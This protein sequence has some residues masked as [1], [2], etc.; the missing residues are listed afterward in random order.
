MRTRSTNFVADRSSAQPKRATSRCRVLAWPAVFGLLSSFLISAPALAQQY[1]LL[2]PGYFN[3]G[4]RWQFNLT[5]DGT[6]SSVTWEIVRAELVGSTDTVV[7][8]ETSSNFSNDINVFLDDTA[9]VI[10]HIEET[11]LS[12]PQRVVSA[13]FSDPL[14]K[15]P[16]RIDA[17]TSNAV[18]GRGVWFSQ[19]ASDPNDNWTRTQDQLVSFV[20]R[21][22]LTVPAFPTTITTTRIVVNETWTKSTGEYGTACRWFWL[23]PTYGFVAAD[24]HLQS[25]DSAGS[26]GP[27]VVVSQRLDSFWSAVPDIRIDGGSTDPTSATAGDA[28]G[29][30]WRE[31]CLFL[32]KDTTH[33]TDVILSADTV[34]DSADRLLLNDVVIPPLAVTGTYDAAGSATVP[35]DLDS[36]DYFIIARVDANDYVAELNELNDFVLNNRLAV[37]ARNQA[38]RWT[39]YP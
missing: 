26:T 39:L 33:V 14:E 35:A 31:I 17:S 4:N 16:R 8:R 22:D 27:L 32:D 13:T 24:Y 37:T 6:A 19:V 2:D 18:L 12:S 15:I 30:S 3:V 11:R 7:L 28:I 1:E 25:A 34:V 21:E 5:I 20:A 10:A 38:H 9:M 36:G 29:I 23:H